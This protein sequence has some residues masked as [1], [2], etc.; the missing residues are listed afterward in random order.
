MFRYVLI[1]ILVLN[2]MGIAYARS[3]YL[4]T[5]H[6]GAL[7]TPCHEKYSY[8]QPYAEN[9]TIIVKNP[10]VID[11][12]P[13]YKKPCHYSSPVEWG[14][15]GDR[16]IFHTKEGICKNC[17]APIKGEYDMHAIHRKNNISVD[18]KTCHMSPVGWNS[19]IV[20]VPAYDNLYIS[21]SILM[22]TS[23]RTPAWGNDCGYCH[24]SAT[25]ARRLHDVHKQVIKIA[26]KECHGQI[27]E[28][29][30]DLIARI[31]EEPLPVEKAKAEPMPI[32]EL[33]MLFDEIVRQFLSFYESLM[34]RKI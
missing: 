7:C 1:I 21:G 34:K 23:I 29:D 3:P 18:C 13:C 19:S 33:S 27:I 16:Y 30:P 28:S 10:E 9:L 4:E 32:R 14:G 8:R 15:V 6:I 31:A 22:N 2:S 11:M 5:W 24:K 12:F 26:C 25:G 20:T 17:H